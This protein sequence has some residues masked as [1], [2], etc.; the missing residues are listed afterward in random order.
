MSI[1]GDALGT[2]MNVETAA[3]R[4]AFTTAHPPGSK[5]VPST[6]DFTA[7]ALAIDQAR[8]N[9]VEAAIEAR[10]PRIFIGTNPTPDPTQFQEGDIYF[11]REE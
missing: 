9:A 4:T 2:A 1:A 5:P 3:E 7:L 10:G 6:A 11:L 8:G